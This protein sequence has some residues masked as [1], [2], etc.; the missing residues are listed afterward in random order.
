MWFSR[1]CRLFFPFLRHVKFILSTTTA[2]AR[3][4]ARAT[5]QNKKAPEVSSSSIK[6]TRQAGCWAVVVAEDFS[7]L[8]SEMKSF[9]G[10]LSNC[11]SFSSFPTATQLVCTL[12]PISVLHD[13]NVLE[14]RLSWSLQYNIYRAV[15]T[16]WHGSGQPTAE[17]SRSY[18]TFLFAGRHT[19]STVDSFYYTV[20]VV[21]RWS[22]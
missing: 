20:Q 14:G 5:P 1:P 18:H 9:L 7:W 15:G 3:P 21:V 10:P 4:T 22:L 19:D 16:L 13:D 8:L 17:D 11:Y 12:A 6:E 2:A